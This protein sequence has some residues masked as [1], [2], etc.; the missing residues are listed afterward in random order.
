MALIFPFPSTVAYFVLAMEKLR[1]DTLPVVFTSAAFVCPAVIF[2][3]FKVTELDSLEVTVKVMELLI[4]EFF[5]ETA[6]MV[7][8]PTALQVTFPFPST[9]AILALE[10]DQVT[11]ASAPEGS[12]VMESWTVSPFL[13]LVEPVI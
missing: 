11:E 7:V 3:S 4:F 1:E 13:A 9:L 10:E 2:I 5:W 6:V 12:A 8:L